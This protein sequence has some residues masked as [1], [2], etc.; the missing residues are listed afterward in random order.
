MPS[1]AKSK[2]PPKKGLQTKR[3]LNKKLMILIVVVIAAIGAYFLFFASAATNNCQ[4]ENGV[5]ICDVDLATS[6]D[7]MLSTGGE[8]ESLGQQ[9]WTYW[10]A[11]FRAPTTAYN[12]AV[13][14]HRVYNG[15]ATYHEFVT[16]AQKSQ[17]EAKYGAQAYE[18]VA[19]YAWTDARQPGTV[20]VYRI[21]QGGLYT[22]SF[23]ST[24]KEWIDQRLAENPNDPN[25]WK[26]DMYA[27]LVAFYA[28]PPNYKV[29]G[30]ANPGQ[31]NPYDCSVYENFVGPNCTKQA[32]SLTTMVNNGTIPKDSTVCPKTFDAYTKNPYNYQL[33]KDCKDFWNAYGLDCNI[34]ENLASNRCTAERE[35]R[36]AEQAAQVKARAAA[37]AAAKKDAKKY[38]NGTT[39]K[40]AKSSTTTRTTNPTTPKK[41]N[42]CPAPKVRDDNGKCLNPGTGTSPTNP[43]PKTCG[44]D[45]RMDD[46]GKCL[47]T[48]PRH[49]CK[50]TFFQDGYSF[51]NLGGGTQDMLYRNSTKYECDR[52]LVSN[53]SNRTLNGLNRKKHNY[54]EYWNGKYVRTIK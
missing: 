11:A 32:E 9:G 5:S 54:K 53:A 52:L 48:L 31:A 10:G 8:A 13:P 37:A 18:G 12:G 35:R 46:N 34:A 27:P 24:S 29:A 22:Y 50:I 20:P 45:Q 1:L 51:L 7:T 14:V 26:A 6:T 44:A 40:P 19:F 33:P 15:N 17:K 43:R 42:D 41:T 25:G 36:A 4:S 16:D 30:Q 39:S 47:S 21:S 28:F 38:P 23:Y 49:D 2:V 3:K